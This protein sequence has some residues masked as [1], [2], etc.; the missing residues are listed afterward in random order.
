MICLK[1]VVIILSTRLEKYHDIIISVYPITNMAGDR[2]GHDKV[3]GFT[4]T[5]VPVQS[6][7]NTTKVV[8]LNPVHGEC[9]RYIM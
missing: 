7:P 9:T 1:C 3:V 6:V 4:T 5:N 2:R 8:S